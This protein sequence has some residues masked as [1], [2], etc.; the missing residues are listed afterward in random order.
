MPFDLNDPKDKEFLQ[1][2]IQK[3]LD[4]QKS[5]LAQSIEKLEA[6]NK[7]LL[8]EKRSVSEQFNAIKDK[9]GD[10]NVDDILK[11]LSMLDQNE[12]A[13]LIAEGKVE[14][15]IARRME[16]TRADYEGKMTGKEKE[17]ESL[18]GERDKLSQR[19]E[20]LVLDQAAAN[21]FV[22]AG[23]L[24]SAVADAVFR[25]RKVFKLENGELVPRDDKGEILKTDNGTV[26]LKEYMSGDEWLRGQAKHLYSQPSGIGARGGNGT[27]GKEANP[28]AKDTL[29]LTK[30]AHLVKT[31]PGKAEQLRKAAERH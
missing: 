21:E 15:V 23:G 11:T 16:R 29:N 30:Q 22:S 28:W 31:D 18:R 20:A 8:G 4:T 3:S 10:R 9:L 14:D 5:E 1:T 19:V 7:E 13:K 27:G 26:T 17:I 2:E 24:P 12:D 25:A 6:K